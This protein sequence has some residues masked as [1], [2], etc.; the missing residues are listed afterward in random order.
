MASLIPIPY[1]EFQVNF[2]STEMD[3]FENETRV[4]VCLEHNRN[5]M[6]EFTVQ[7]GNSPH[8]NRNTSASKG[9]IYYDVILCVHIILSTSRLKIP[10]HCIIRTVHRYVCNHT[11]YYNPIHNLNNAI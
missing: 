6:E 3:A 5:C 9:H 1:T 2:V 7:V 8:S 10:Q 11:K 4:R